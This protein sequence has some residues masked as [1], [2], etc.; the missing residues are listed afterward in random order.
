M[1]VLLLQFS[2]VTFY[3]SSNTENVK[4]NGIADNKATATLA[5]VLFPFLK[6]SK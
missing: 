2:D 5:Y 3:L 1:A 4:L 6:Q